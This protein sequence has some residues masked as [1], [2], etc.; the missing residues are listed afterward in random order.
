MPSTILGVLEI[1]FH[2]ILV[3]VLQSKHCYY[4]HFTQEEVEKQKLLSL[5]QGHTVDE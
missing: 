1:L 2:L 4:S 5:A 3:T